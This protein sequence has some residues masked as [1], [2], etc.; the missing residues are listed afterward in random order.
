MKALFVHVSTDEIYGD[1]VNQDSFSEKSILKPSNPYSATK[2]AA[3]HLVNSYARTYGVKCIIT[4][5]TN[6]FGPFQFPE[7]LIPK[8]IIRAQKNLKVPSI[9]RW[10]SNS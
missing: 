7:K 3:D 6:N 8:T 5:C 2:A 1:A 9:W 10:K 4:R